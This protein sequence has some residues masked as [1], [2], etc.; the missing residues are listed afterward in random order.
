M[1]VQ[2]GQVDLA[3]DFDR[4]RNSMIESGKV[5]PESHKIVWTSDPL[6]NDCIAAAK[7][8]PQELVDKVQKLLVAITPEQAKTLLPKHYTGFV[9]ANHAS[10]ESIE[11]AGIAV[12][13]IKSRT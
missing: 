2:S 8:T 6:P 9:A 1:A 4:N 13:K 12:G 5:K 11:K 7:G 10:Y 3:T